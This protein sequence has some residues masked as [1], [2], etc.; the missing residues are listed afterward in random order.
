MLIRLLCANE[1]TKHVCKISRLNS[2]RLP[3]KLQK[4]LGGYFILPHPVYISMSPPLHILAGPVPSWMPLSTHTHTRTHAR[5][6]THTHRF[7]GHFHGETGLTVWPPHQYHSSQKRINLNSN[8]I[9]KAHL[10]ESLKTAVIERQ[11]D[12]RGGIQPSEGVTVHE[13][14]ALSWHTHTHIHTVTHTHC[15]H[16]LV[17]VGNQLKLQHFVSSISNKN[18]ML[19]FWWWWFYWSFARLLA[20][21]VQLSP[22]P[23]SSFASINTS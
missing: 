15:W 13:E 7:K 16:K 22:P 4:L 9:K 17:S 1:M 8:N 3:R 19:V 5:T 12:S 11:H 14:P 21:L 20:P 23:P 6:H 10:I 2:K 18:W